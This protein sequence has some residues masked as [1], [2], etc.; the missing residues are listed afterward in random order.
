MLLL[1]CL[2]EDSAVLKISVIGDSSEAIEFALEGKLV[3]PWVDELDRLS[4]EALSQNKSLTLNLERVWFVDAR[5]A[6]LLRDLA[7]RH[8]SQN[9]CSQFVSQ[10]VREAGQ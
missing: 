4:Q 5:G 2:S 3:G 10:Q 1:V 7:E 6:A 8:V 9:N